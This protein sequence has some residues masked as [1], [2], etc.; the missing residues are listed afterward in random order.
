MVRQ[1]QKEATLKAW[2][3]EVA[4]VLWVRPE[5]GHPKYRSGDFSKKPTKKQRETLFCVAYGALLALNWGEDVR[6][7][8]EKGN[9][10]AQ[11]II[12]NAEFTADLLFEKL[13]GEDERLQGYLT[14]YCPLKEVL[15]KWA[16][17]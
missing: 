14:I 7:D 8:D 10:K 11:A 4:S 6:R 16:T 2:A 5:Q 13:L 15:R 12:D 1:Y 17:N 3:D 9:A